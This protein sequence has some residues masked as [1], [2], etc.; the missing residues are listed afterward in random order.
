MLN[1]IGAVLT[2]YLLH[3]GVHLTSFW[4]AIL[5]A[6]VLA[7][8]NASV[9]PVLV[10]LTIP[11]T[12]FSLGLFLLVINALI[13]EMAAWILQPGFVVDSFW[14]A[15]LFQCVVLSIIN[16]VFDRITVK[17]EYRDDSVKIYDKDG[18]RIV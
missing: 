11:A 18:K 10:F 12:I 15:L 7:L 14:W 17:P 8:L 1:A 3:S 5:L 16:G 4:Y 13:I 9:K 2:A 6:A